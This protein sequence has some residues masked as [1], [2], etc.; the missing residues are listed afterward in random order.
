MAPNDMI[1]EEEKLDPD[2]SEKSQTGKRK[3]SKGKKQ[4]RLTNLAAYRLSDDSVVVKLN[5]EDKSSACLNSKQDRRVSF[6][7]DSMEKIKPGQS[8]KVFKRIRRNKTAGISNGRV[9]RQPYVVIDSRE[10]K[11]HIGSG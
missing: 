8:I 9:V 10:E 4:Q 2:P 1:K 7:D 5:S 3:K 6:G 11:E